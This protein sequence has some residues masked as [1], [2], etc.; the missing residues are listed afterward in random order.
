MKKLYLSRDEK[1]IFG[2]CG[3]LAEVFD[4]DPTIVRLCLIFATLAT[5]ILPFVL[6]YIIAG[7]ITPNEP[8]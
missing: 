5:G 4:I 3:G 2:L 8:V 7:I 1:K 6:T